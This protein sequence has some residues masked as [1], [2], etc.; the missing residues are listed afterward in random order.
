[1]PNDVKFTDHLRILCDRS[2]DE[3]G[4]NPTRFREM[5]HARGGLGAAKFVINA[6]HIGDGFTEMCIQGR[7]D[8][9]V[10]AQAISDEWCDLFTEDELEKAIRKLKNAEYSGNLICSCLPQARVLQE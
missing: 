3:C 5:L 9:T 7:L 2:R 8:L 10:E 6:A 4:Y 1:M